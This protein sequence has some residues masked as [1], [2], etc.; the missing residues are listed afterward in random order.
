ME[1]VRFIF[2]ELLKILGVSFLSLL[3]VKGVASL[4]VP[5][6]LARAKVFLYALVLA[7]AGDLRMADRVRRI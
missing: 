2:W 3:A 5:S 6:R 1:Q 4:K 7:M